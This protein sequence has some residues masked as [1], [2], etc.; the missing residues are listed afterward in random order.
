MAETR[1]S[2]GHRLW[3]YQAERFPLARNGLLIAM[4]S[5]AGATLS[6]VLGG[7]TPPAAGAYAVAFMV[8]FLAFYQLRA[9]DEVKDAE[10]DRRFR[11]ERAV[12]RGLVSLR[13]LVGLGVAAAIC[14][15]VAAVWLDARLLA[16]LGVVWLWMAAMSMEFG[17]RVWLRGRPLTYMVSHMMIMPLI[18]FFVTA[19]E[20]M[21]RA[22]KPP[23]ALM[24]FLLLSFA[25]G[26]VIEIGRKTRAPENERSG[27]DSYSRLWGPRRAV[28]AWMA[29][30]TAAEALAVAVGVDA[31]ATM[32]VT[33]GAV[34]AAL[35]AL[36]AALAFL[37]D[38]TPRAQ[39]AVDQGAGLWVLGSYLS[40][41]LGPV[42]A[43]M[44]A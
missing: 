35:P 31:G 4:F 43:R 30:L 40:V 13:L 37:R 17:A 20:W 7:R 2:L 24:A 28:A 14:Q 9:A 25:N 29:A 33:A 6:A 23:T 22:G 26:C 32:W 34:L 5:A 38:P 11:P 12:P 27:V 44:A 41:G 16:L 1:H 3:I 18:D 15:A 10:D 36:R 19:C 39:A 8:A 42:L 21:P